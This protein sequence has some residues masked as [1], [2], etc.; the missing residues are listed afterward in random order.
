MPL[1]L[2]HDFSAK[3]FEAGLPGLDEAEQVEEK[4][5]KDDRKRRNAE[6]WQEFFSTAG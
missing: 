3:I 2:P 4:P 1:I 6:T 5:C